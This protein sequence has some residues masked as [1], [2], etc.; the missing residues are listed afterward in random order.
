MKAK[1][2]SLD[3]PEL[4]TFGIISIDEKILD[5]HPSSGFQRCTLCSCGEFKP[6]NEYPPYGKC[7]TAGCGHEYNDH[8]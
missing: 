1:L 4:D 6:K 2:P 8:N 3:L 7:Q 5:E